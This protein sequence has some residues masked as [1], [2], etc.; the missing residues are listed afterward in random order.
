[1]KLSSLSTARAADVLCEI[2][3]YIANITADKGLLDILSTKLGAENRSVAE[4]YVY[5]AKKIASIAP[6]ILKT[7]RDD[8]FGLLAAVNETTAEEIA[9]QNIIKTMSQIRDLAHD[10]EFIDFFKSWQQSEETP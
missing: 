8:V 3:P 5:G 7:H 9:A 4:L 6:I 1:M 2:T 10:Q